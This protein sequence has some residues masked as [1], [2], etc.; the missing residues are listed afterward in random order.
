MDRADVVSL[1]GH[2]EGEW[3]LPALQQGTDLVKDV[4]HDV[5]DEDGL[6]GEA[7]VGQVVNGH[8]R[9]GQQ[10]VRGVVGQDA[11]VFFGHATVK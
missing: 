9:G 7:L 4:G 1:R 10:Q 5:A 2:V 8:V 3:L 6:G 11:V